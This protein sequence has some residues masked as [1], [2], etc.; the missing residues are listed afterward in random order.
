[1]RTQNAQNKQNSQKLGTENPQNKQN[2]QKGELEEFDDAASIFA[3]RFRYR[4]EVC[5]VCNAFHDRQFFLVI[6]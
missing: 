2:A 6:G 3:G 5:H 1:M 4:M